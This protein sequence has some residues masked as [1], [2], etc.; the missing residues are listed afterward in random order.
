MN[1]NKFD[2]MGTVYSKFRPSYPE[3]FIEYLYSKIALSKDSII[4][5]IG[6]GTG[7]LTKQLLEQGSRVF[8]VEP[9][10]DMRKIADMTLGEF[11]GY[12]SVK[13]TAENTAILPNCVD[14][15]TAAQSSFIGLIKLC[16]KMSVKGY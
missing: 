7:I 15:I 11:S 5:D 13:A 14:F 9:N 4:A 1:E 16:L 2:N 8:A 3:K 10:D 12:V 6:S